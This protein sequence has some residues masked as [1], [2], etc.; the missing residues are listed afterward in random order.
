VVD[1]LIRAT[2]AQSNGL[3]FPWPVPL[4]DFLEIRAVVSMDDPEVYGDTFDFL[5]FKAALEQEPPI[6]C[7]YKIVTMVISRVE[8]E[9]LVTQNRYL[10]PE[11]VRWDEEVEAH[12]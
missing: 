5:P 4:G 2:I 9:K 11:G 10:R 1:G 8:I 12:R 3:R 7:D 6:V